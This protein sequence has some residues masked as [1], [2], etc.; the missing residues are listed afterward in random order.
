MGFN[1][2]QAKKIGTPPPEKSSVVIKDPTKK[3]IRKSRSRI[4]R[5]DN[6]KSDI[7]LGIESYPY[8]YVYDYYEP[9]SA[10]KHLIGIEVDIPK[11]KHI[12]TGM[13]LLHRISDK[14]LLY[15]VRNYRLI[16]LK[17]VQMYLNQRL[18]KILGIGLSERRAENQ[19]SNLNIE[20]QLI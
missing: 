13:G 14:E 7:T 3:K 1:F 17:K 16:V 15:M 12:F 5:K 9:H 4:K 20:L 10:F 19:I 8:G 18:R 11:N 2:A 6:I